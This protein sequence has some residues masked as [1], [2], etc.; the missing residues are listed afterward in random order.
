MRL[1]IKIS[2]HDLECYPIDILTVEA[3]KLL[4]NPKKCKISMSN[5]VLS[6]VVEL[7]LVDELVN[8]NSLLVSNSVTQL[9]DITK[10]PTKN[11]TFFDSA[12]P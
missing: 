7:P 3:R 5:T 1:L 12:T 10:G 8:H 4:I 2:E 6:S 11:V 9:N